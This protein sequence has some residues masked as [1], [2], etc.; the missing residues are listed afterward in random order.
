MPDRHAIPRFRR[1]RHRRPEAAKS[2]TDTAAI[3]MIAPQ[4][5]SPLAKNTMCTL[6]ARQSRDA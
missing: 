3:V 6:L 4:V 2:A 5:H 1:E